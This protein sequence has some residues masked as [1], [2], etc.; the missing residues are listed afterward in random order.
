MLYWKNA[1]L[2]EELMVTASAVNKNLSI[3][4]YCSKG[5]FFRYRNVDR[6][7]LDR[8]SSAI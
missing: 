6:S 8:F 2:A 5:Y 3:V 1:Y 7:Y 4:K